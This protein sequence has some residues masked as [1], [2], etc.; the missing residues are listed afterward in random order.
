M[1]ATEISK[2]LMQDDSKMK[3]FEELTVSG[4]TQLIERELSTVCSD[5][6]ELAA[7]R[8]IILEHLTGKR[9]EA[10]WAEPDVLLDAAVASAASSILAR[11]KN[12]EPLQYILEETYFYGLRFE[13]KRGVLIPRAD[14]E[15][16]VELVLKNCRSKSNALIGEIGSGSGNIA[17]SLLKNLPEAQVWACDLSE[18]AQEMT[19][20]NANLH[21]VSERL[22]FQL[23][24]WKVWL[25]DLPGQLD[26]LV[27]NP[28]YIAAE[29]E[30]S[31]EAEVRLYE[32]RLALFGTGSDGLGFYREFAERAQ[33]SLIPLAPIFLELG[34]GQSAPVSEV[35]AKQGWS[36]ISLHKDL[37]GI[38]RVLSARRPK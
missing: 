6:H 38:E 24:D 9:R 8:E 29:L 4:L 18:R 19:L 22:Q 2:S 7:E 12:R 27:S 13:I 32:P 16:L 15:T 3:Q 21:G 34:F 25:Q 23:C 11:R 26:C 33:A 1:K 17:I 36:D 5:E 31:L 10:R 30:P 20:Q 35:F 28:P 37:N 14:T